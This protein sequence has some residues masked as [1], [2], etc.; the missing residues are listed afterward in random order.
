[1]I[2]RERASVPPPK[3]LLSRA[4]KPLGALRSFYELERSVR[5]QRRAPEDLSLLADSS[6]QAALL[7]LFDGKCAYCESPLAAVKFDVDRFARRAT[8]WT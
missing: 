1:M 8:R 6:L 3:R 4:R 5:S 2:H 7:K